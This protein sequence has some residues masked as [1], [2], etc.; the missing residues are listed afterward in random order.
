[1]KQY[2]G[3]LILGIIEI[4]IGGV[5]LCGVF[6]SIVLGINTKTPNVLL[7]VVT[8]ATMSTL[9]GIG[10]LRLRVEAYKL[11]YFFS[12]V[13]LLSKILIL[14]DIIRLNGALASFIPGFCRDIVSAVY[15]AFI[16]Y[17]LRRPGIKTIFHL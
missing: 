5:T 15:H 14:L 3:I 16:L 17:Y 7:F 9:I 1:M 11:L 6:A 12:S 10:L 2:R 4:L 8:T 13:I